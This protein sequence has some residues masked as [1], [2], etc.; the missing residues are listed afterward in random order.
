MLPI[1][2]IVFMIANGWMWDPETDRLVN[3]YINFFL[4]GVGAIALSTGLVLYFI[5][6]ISQDRTRKN[7]SENIL[8]FG[9]AVILLGFILFMKSLLE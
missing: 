8:L 2:I 4:I 6:R 5:A 3:I 9:G 7:R 1:G